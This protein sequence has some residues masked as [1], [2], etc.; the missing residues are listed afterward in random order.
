MPHL[1][2]FVP[3]HTL[4]L[5]TH[6]AAPVAHHAIGVGLGFGLLVLFFGSVLGLMVL[7]GHL[8]H[9]RRNRG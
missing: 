3:S 2:T 8:R 1:L 7:T 4:P 6:A 9:R 5:D